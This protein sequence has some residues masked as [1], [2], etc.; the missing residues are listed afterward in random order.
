ML[1]AAVTGER[2]PAAAGPLGEAELVAA[3]SACVEVA[4][5]AV[6]HIPVRAPGWPGVYR[7]QFKMVDTEGAFCFPGQN[8]LGIEVMMQVVRREEP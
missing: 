4:E 2:V 7:Q 8:T 5:V 6:L 1:L 3:A